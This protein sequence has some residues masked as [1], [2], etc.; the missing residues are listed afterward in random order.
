MFRTITSRRLV[1]AGSDLN[2]AG[3]LANRCRRLLA[4]SPVQP[5]AQHDRHTEEGAHEL[6]GDH[7]IDHYGF[8]AN[9]RL[10]ARRYFSRAKSQ[11]LMAA[12]SE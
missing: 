7:I 6:L 4:Q 3:E 10:R 12:R 5:Q 8:I 11:A 9:W 2:G 1:R